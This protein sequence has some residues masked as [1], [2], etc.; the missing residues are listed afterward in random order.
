MQLVKIKDKLIFITRCRDKFYAA[1]NECPHEG[2]LLHEGEVSFRREVVCPWHGYRF[3]LEN[4][5]E[6]SGKNCR[7][8]TTYNI[9]VDGDG[10]FV[11]IN[12]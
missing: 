6:T 4:G 3:S 7:P 2:G 12:V 10:V 5:T 9:R 1:D 11:H 8:L